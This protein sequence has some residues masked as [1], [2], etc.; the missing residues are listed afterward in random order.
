MILHNKAPR[1]LCVVHRVVG[2]VVKRFSLI[3]EVNRNL[4]SEFMEKTK[5]INEPL[6]VCFSST[7]GETRYAI[8]L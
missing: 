8:L 1:F 7:G 5:G 2:E 3:G 6:N 4:V